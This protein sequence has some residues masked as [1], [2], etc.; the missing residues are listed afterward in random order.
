M[1]LST[2]FEHWSI[3]ENPF[4]GEEARHDA[5][6]ARMGGEEPD[7]AGTHSDFEKVLGDL[8]RPSAAIVFGEKGAGKT[9]MRLQL[10][11]RVARH[12]E[13]HP[14]GRVFL[15]PYDDLNAPLDHFVRVT[16]SRRGE[17]GNPFAS[18]R[19]VDHIDGILSV[20]VGRVVNAMLAG[21]QD[22]PPAK[23]APGRDDPDPLRTA[24]RL[25]AAV[26]R[27]ILIL[28]AI[29]DTND[30][31]GARTAR[32]ARALRLPPGGSGPLTVIGL[33]LGWIPAASLFVWVSF[34]SG[35]SGFLGTLGQLGSG[36]LLARPARLGRT[37]ARVGG[38]ARQGAAARPARARAPRGASGQGAQDGPASGAR[39]A[40]VARV[41]P[42]QPDRTG[43]TSRD[44]F[45]RA[46]LRD[47]RASP[48]RDRRLRVRRG[49][50]RD[51]PGRRADA[52]A[53]RDGPHAC[54]RVAHAQQQVPPAR[55]GRGQDAPAYRAAPRAVQR[56]ERVL[57]GGA[58]GQ[59]EPHRASDLVGAGLCS[60]TCARRACV[61]ACARARN[62]SR[63]RISSTR[64]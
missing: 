58:P 55:G 20:G 23:L 28:Q 26:R 4:R 15:I 3:A 53:G 22:P 44:R 1:N 62:R 21:A 8:S 31:S 13:T 64:A 33:W 10:A 56:I 11:S 17:G 27:D 39:A 24:R 51:R 6:F 9:A 57:P 38:A 30:P 63:S 29:Y 12:N 41:P 34:F 32:L 50:G 16:G 48:P 19:L 36:V 37:A 43:R 42:Q 25:P 46:A 47:A 14:S 18:M 49:D 59:A 40:R 45:G 61:C 52:R 35:L 2:F 54:D 60:T 7:A 5:I